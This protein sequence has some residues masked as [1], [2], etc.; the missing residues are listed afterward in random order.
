V[1]QLFDEQRGEWAGVR[2]QL[3]AL[4]GERGYEAAQRTTI[5]ADYTDPQVAAAIRLA[6]VDL[7]FSGG[8]VLEPGCGAGILFGVAPEG[9][10]L[11]G[12]ELDP[13]TAQ[14]ARALHPH[15]TIRA[16]SFA[17]MRLPDGHF[18][19]AIGNVPFADVRLHDPRPQTRAG[20]A[21]TSTSSSSRWR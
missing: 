10:E 21:C 2:E 5:N 9:V 1:P 13:S 19:L 7:G 20:T 11:T 14:I 8:R 4:A 18:D 12:V 16:E 15:A 3:R 17:A 6:V